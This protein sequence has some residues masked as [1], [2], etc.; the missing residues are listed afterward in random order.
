MC[1][2]ISA[3]PFGSLFL[4]LTTHASL[5]REYAAADFRWGTAD[6]TVVSLELLTVLGAG[7]LCCYILHLLMLSDPARHYWIVV[8]CTAEL[9]GGLGHFN[10]L[11]LLDSDSNS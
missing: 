5:G 4:Y 6:P 1:V 3:S 8:L 9:Y 7:P 2:D 10:S 11:F